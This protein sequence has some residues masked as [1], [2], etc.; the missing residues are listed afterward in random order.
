[1]LLVGWT[2]LG[3][4]FVKFV[5]CKSLPFF[6]SEGW[7]RSIPEPSAFFAGVRLAGKLSRFD[8]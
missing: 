1:M 2:V 7:V 3:V 6:E 4:G 8:E 5:G